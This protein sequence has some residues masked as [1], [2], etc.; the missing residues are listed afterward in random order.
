MWRGIMGEGNKKGGGEPPTTLP[1]KWPQLNLEQ[2]RVNVENMSREGQ[3]VGKSV[4]R[5]VQPQ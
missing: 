1:F 5:G 3:R 2:T 4:R